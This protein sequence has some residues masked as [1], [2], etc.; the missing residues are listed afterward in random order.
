METTV[1]GFLV[2]VIVLAGLT[3]VK[4]LEMVLVESTGLHVVGLRVFVNVRVLVFT[5]QMLHFG[6]Q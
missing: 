5:G 1:E 3:V 6:I 2:I 4:T